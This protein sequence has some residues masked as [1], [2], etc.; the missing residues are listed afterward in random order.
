[1]IKAIIWSITLLF[2]FSYSITLQEVIKLA[3]ER[4]TQIKLSQLDLQKVQ[5]QIKEVKSNLYPKIVLNGNYSRIDKNLNTGFTLENQYRASISVIQKVFDKTVFESLKYAKQSIKLQKAIKNQIKTKV[6]DTAQRLYFAVLLRKSILGL[7]KETLNYWKKN[8]EYTQEKFNVGLTNKFNLLRTKA[9]YNLALSDYRQALS[10]YKK[11][12]IDL[13]RFLFLQEITPPQ[14]DLKKLSFK[15]IDFSKIE[16]KNPELLVYKE[17]INVAQK[18]IDVAKATNYPT[19]ELQA[20]YRT[21]NTIRFPELKEF[22]LKGYTISLNFN[23]VIY[24][25]MQK[26]SKI[27]QSKIDKLKEELNLK[28]KVEKLK[29]E[30]EKILEDINTLET[31]LEALKINLEASKEA[32]NLSTERYKYGLTDIIEVLD[33]QRAYDEAYIQYLLNLYNYDMKVFDLHLLTGYE[34]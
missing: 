14:E 27:I 34:F 4:A 2:S 13:K 15:K 24:D 10:D 28:D 5:A 18:Q 21:F 12:L 32:L 33:S 22:W 25:G 7:K 23:F 31:K 6:I 30:Y 3:E 1:M 11:A 9:Q 16:K 19:L 26:K 20:E 17:K 8:L 29:G